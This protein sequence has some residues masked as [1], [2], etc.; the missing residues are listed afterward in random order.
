MGDLVCCGELTV[1]AAA[2]PETG[3]IEAIERLPFV[4]PDFTRHSWVGERARIVW[5]PRIQRICE[6]WA[7]VEWLS[8][9]EGVRQCALVGLS[10]EGI[11][12]VGAA[13]DR[14]SSQRLRLAAGRVACLPGIDVHPGGWSR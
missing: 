4:L 9:S 7:D 14:A 8:V 11:S 2:R 13:V 1:T 12:R 6:A 10:Q 3:F 5:E